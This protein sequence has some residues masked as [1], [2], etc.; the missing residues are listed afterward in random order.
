MEGNREISDGTLRIRLSGEG[1]RQTLA[2]SGELDLANAGTLE[3]ELRR[4]A[5]DGEQIVLD[6]RG[7]EFIDST[8]IAV[9]VATHR[10]LND[11]ASRVRLVHSDAP[12]VRRVIQ[13]TGL[14][15]ELPFVDG[16]EPVSGSQPPL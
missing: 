7:L 8:G 13:I 5:E 4:A 15:S 11:G 9:L 16:G 3:A 14:E 12:A 6:L 1:S 2:V 10:R